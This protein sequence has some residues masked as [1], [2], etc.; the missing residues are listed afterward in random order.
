MF[1]Y[2]LNRNFFKLANLLNL[3]L[4]FTF[5]C[6]SIVHDPALS[7]TTKEYFLNYILRYLKTKPH[8]TFV[9][10]QIIHFSIFFQNKIC[11][12][13]ISRP[14]NILQ[15]TSSACFLRHNDILVDTNNVA[16]NLK[17]C[18]IVICVLGI[19]RKL[20]KWSDILV[21]FNVGYKNNNSQSNFLF[22]LVVL[23]SRRFKVEKIFNLP[24]NCIFE[25][26]YNYLLLFL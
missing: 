7:P 14:H 23:S 10:N 11:Y 20:W 19:Q 22:Y 9:W 21:F 1:I 8:I 2:V 3:G 17:P 13:V 24:K 12:Y 15:L 25:P 18:L 4:Q 16:D 5:S 26:D 6:N